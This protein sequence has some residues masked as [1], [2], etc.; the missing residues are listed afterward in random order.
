MF[1]KQSAATLLAEFIGTGILTLMIL[2][3]QRSTI[4]VP[5]FVAAGAGLALLVITYALH[6]TSGAHFN[7][8]LTVALWTARKIS[9]VSGVLYIIAQLLGAWAAY[10]LYTYFVN[11]HLSPVGGHYTSRILVAEGVGTA[12][13]SFGVAST[14]YRRYSLGGV[15]SFSGAAYML[16]IITASSASIG[17]LN[18]AVALGVRAW[19]WG[20]YVLGPVL[21]AIIGV[22]LYALLFAQ[23]EAAG[24]SG[25]SGPAIAAVASRAARS[26]KKAK[27]ARK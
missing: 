7:P 2:S 14:V 24:S 13:F 6:E 19:V 15:A 27:S 9:T 12:I 5:F 10:G 18:P 17:L 3:V 4:G 11:T 23:P 20:T 22:N 21:G 26:A 25:S 8:A 16:G 1:G